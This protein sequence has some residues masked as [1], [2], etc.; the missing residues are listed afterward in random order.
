M[1]GY[2]LPSLAAEPNSGPT[3]QTAPRTS[4]IFRDVGEETGAGKYLTSLRAHG[5]AWGDVDNDG[6]LDLFVTAFHNAGSAPAVLL[7]NKDGRFTPD[8]QPAARTSGAGSGALFVDLTNGGKLDL[9]VS[10]CAHRSKEPQ[11]Q[12]PGVLLRNDGEGKFRDVSSN[13]GA[14]PEN[15]AG[16]GVAAL[17]YDGDGLLDLA[18]CERYYGEVEHGP[19]LFRN[20]G[21]HKFTDVGSEAGLPPKFS[22][23]GVAAADLNGDGR[24]DLFFTGG[25]GHCRMFI[26]RNGRKFEESA[27]ANEVFHWR[28]KTADDNPA[29]VAIGDVT[30]DGRPDIVVGHHF[31]KPWST[32]TPVR[33]YI[34]RGEKNGIPVYFDATESAGIMPLAMKAPH[35]EI[36]DFNNDGLNDIYVSIVKFAEGKP[37]PIIFRN[38]G[39]TNGLPA[40]QTDAWTVN[41]FPTEEDRN[42]R[43]STTPFFDRLRREKK[44]L[45]SA[46][47]PSG[48]YDRDGRI[49]LVVTNWYVE[50]QG[51]LLKNETAAGY[52][53]DVAVDGPPG[54][55]RMGVVRQGSLVSDRQS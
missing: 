26:N 29:G 38:L 4:F 24:P 49:D 37:Y 36:Q 28:P 42:H 5:A 27:E 22:G 8:E 25:D 15:F 6:E 35:V 21:N 14:I 55:N 47:A 32:P 16:R 46:A 18:M 50:D 12:N 1:T 44:I 51:L 40:F 41:D 10:N 20:L 45:Y 43:G 53:L 30:G 19:R 34:H 39:V 9:F 17:D 52:W 54:T 48:D 13:C 3:Y 2:V 31:K 11:L 23:L 33:L 7:R